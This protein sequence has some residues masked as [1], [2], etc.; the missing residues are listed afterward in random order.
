[1]EFAGLI[2]SPDLIPVPWMWIQGLLMT[3]FVVHLLFMNAMLGTGIIALV[4]LFRRRASDLSVAKA[5][6]TTLPTFI[7]FT[8]NA[9]VAPLLFLY[10]LYGQF[11]LTSSTL[12]AVWWLSVVGILLMAY[13]AAYLFDFKFDAMGAARAWAIAVTTGLLLIV[14]FLFSNN[15]TLMLSPDRWSRYLENPGGTLLNLADPMLIPRYLHFVTASVAVGG[16]VLAWMWRLKASKGVAG[17]Q[18]KSRQAMG[19]FTGATTVQFAV[20]TVFLFSLPRGIRSLF[21]GGEATATGL[22]AAS[23]AAAILALH[24]GFRGKIRS[25]TA[26]TVITIIFM[27]LVRDRVRQAFLAPVFSPADLPVVLQNGPFV[28][29]LAALALSIAAVV[30][31]IRLAFGSG[32]EL[33][34]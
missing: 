11:I 26:A 19:W 4:A 8:V 24:L 1:M 14:G 20:G 3:T 23:I 27:V 29:F 5:I 13:Y 32:Q 7:A 10:V 6:S 17:A 34:P 28:L 18:E 16:L 33:R 31:M 21:L 12:M 15:M 22:L 9:G 2:P 25:C 30:F